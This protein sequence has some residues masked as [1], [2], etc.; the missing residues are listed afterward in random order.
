MSAGA[1]KSNFELFEM[2]VVDASL[3][4]DFFHDLAR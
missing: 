3:E 2:V 1:M 4:G